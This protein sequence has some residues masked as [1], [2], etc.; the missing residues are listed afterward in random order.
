LTGDL[1]DIETQG[2][3][4]IGQFVEAKPLRI[5]R[6]VSSY[7]LS[8]NPFTKDR[9]QH[10]VLMY[11]AAFVLVEGV[12]RREYLTCTTLHPGFLK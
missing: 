8:G 5:K 2:K 3:A 1:G 9:N 12:H 6:I 4:G 10:E 11:P 7:G